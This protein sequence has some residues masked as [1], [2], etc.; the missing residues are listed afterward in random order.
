M[1]FLSDRCQLRLIYSTRSVASGKWQDIRDMLLITLQGA[2]TSGFINIAY[3]MA[4]T[5]A[6]YLLY[7]LHTTAY[8]GSTAGG[9]PVRGAAPE[10]LVA[11]VAA[12]DG[13]PGAAAGQRGSGI[14]WEPRGGSENGADYAIGRRELKSNNRER[15]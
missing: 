11:I 5:T 1:R 3:F 6:L 10:E 13:S 4:A 9:A 14:G 2:G 8:K 12:G 15:E 7:S